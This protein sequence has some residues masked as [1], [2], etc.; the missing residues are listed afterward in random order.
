MTS[1]SI[2]LSDHGLRIRGVSWLGIC[3]EC[4]CDEDR[5]QPHDATCVR[6]RE[7]EEARIAAEIASTNQERD[8]VNTYEQAA[9]QKKVEA[10]VKEIDSVILE[11]GVDDA[12]LVLSLLKDGDVDWKGISQSAGCRCPS[13]KTIAAVLAVY[14]ERAR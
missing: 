2:H 7:I 9:R 5:K 1:N 13:K 11:A 8:P 3:P 4:E 12:K 10:L 6:G 14:E